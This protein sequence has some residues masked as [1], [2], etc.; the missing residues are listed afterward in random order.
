MRRRLHRPAAHA[1]NETRN[2][3]L[4]VPASRRWQ[5]LKNSWGPAFGEGG[6][7]RIQHGVSCLGL[8]GACQAY[9]GEPP[10]AAV[11]AI[12]VEEQQA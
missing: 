9:I 3:Q 5:K 6:Y 4:R 11:G 1:P 10:G 12:A 2:R 8:R 7:M